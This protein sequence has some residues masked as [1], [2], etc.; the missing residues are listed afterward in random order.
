MTREEEDILLRK[1]M[2]ESPSYIDLD[3][4]IPLAWDS[5]NNKWLNAKQLTEREGNE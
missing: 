5:T 2:M 4:P 3:D 1:L